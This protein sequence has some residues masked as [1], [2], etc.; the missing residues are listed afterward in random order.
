MQMLF[1]TFDVGSLALK[2]AP[3]LAL[4]SSGRVTGLSLHVGYSHTQV[5]AIFDGYSM[6][7]T[8]HKNEV[9]GKWITEQ[10]C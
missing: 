6:A 10:L 2:N 3:A 9:A 8:S 5:A 1:E 7:H 4:L